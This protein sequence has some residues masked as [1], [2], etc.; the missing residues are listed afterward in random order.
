MKKG[1]FIAVATLVL[2]FSFTITVCAKTENTQDFLDEQYKI[3]GADELNGALPESVREYMEQNGINPLEYANGQKLTSQSVFSHI[4][5]F[6]KTGFKKPLACGCCILAIILISGL[7]RS[8]QSGAGVEVAVNYATTLSAAAVISLPVLNVISASVNAMQGC[9]VFMTSFIPV[10]AVITASSGAAITSASMS[11]LLLG[12]TQV[13]NWIS[14]F[15]VTPLM[16]GYLSFSIASSVSVSLSSS[17]IAGGIKKVAYWIMSL[18]TTLF[19]GVLSLQTA[20]NASADNLASRT[21]KFILG[22]SVPLAGPVL[23]ETLNTVT[24]SMGILKA[25]VGV[26]GVVAV[27]LIFLPLITE[28]FIWRFALIINAGIADMFSVPNISGLLRAVDTV[29]SVLSGI[30]LLT[31]AMFIISLSI[32]ISAGKQV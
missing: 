5:D 30:I 26:Y 1:F 8:S 24:A 17:G 25:S 4:L 9:T 15:A 32:V 29:M 6:L 31:M 2:I 7:I 27:T 19:I 18:I 28:L 22:T 13:V 10:F 12:A 20:I 11:A 16:S 14:S 23:S 3:S 21:A